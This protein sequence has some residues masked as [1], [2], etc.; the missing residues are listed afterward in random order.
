MLRCCLLFSLQIFDNHIVH[1]P[2]VAHLFM[3]KNLAYFFEIA[4]RDVRNVVKV[5]PG[6]ACVPIEA[7]GPIQTEPE[8]VLETLAVTA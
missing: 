4:L 8:L 5:A 6:P 1:G 7:I 2:I 3:V